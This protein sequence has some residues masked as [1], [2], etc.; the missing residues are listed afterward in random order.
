MIFRNWWSI[1]LGVSI[2]MLRSMRQ[3][4]GS[5]PSRYATWSSRL[6]NK[7]RTHEQ[8]RWFLRKIEIFSLF[9]SFSD[10][11]RTNSVTQS[12]ATYGENRWSIMDNNK[13]ISI[14]TENIKSNNNL[15]Y[16]FF[17]IDLHVDTYVV[18]CIR[19][20]LFIPF[21]RYGNYNF[22]MCCT[23]KASSVKTTIWC[24][25][26]KYWLNIIFSNLQNRNA[27][28]SANP[29]WKKRYSIDNA[30]HSFW[31]FFYCVFLTKLE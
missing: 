19:L 13:C 28:F 1:I 11:S 3:R 22:P 15:K 29:S 17:F 2:D 30:K 18:Y 21:L 10:L 4:D 26:Q 14:I 5:V 16:D 27:S 25:P 7:K 31:L 6:V 24:M 20:R 12:Q 8:G 23:D 9:Q